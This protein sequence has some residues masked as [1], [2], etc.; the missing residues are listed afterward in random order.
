MVL[1]HMLDDRQ[2]DL[3]HPNQ[4]D[5]MLADYDGLRNQH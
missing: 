5:E 2:N 3:Y 1:E 4:S